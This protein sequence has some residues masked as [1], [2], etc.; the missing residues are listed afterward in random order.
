M[1]LFSEGR[2]IGISEDSKMSTDFNQVP[3]FSHPPESWHTIDWSVVNRQVRG[4]QVRIA[5]A[6][7]EKRWRK[8]K[9]LQRLLTHSFAARTLAVRRVTENRGKKTPGVDGELWSTPQAKWLALGRL[10]RKGYRPAPL[11]RVYIPK[12]DGSRRPLGIPTMRDRAMQALYL[13]ALEPVSETV[14]DRNSYGFRPWRSTADAIEQCFV[15]LRRKH[16]AEWVLEGDIKGCFDNISHDWLLANVPMDKHVLKM[17]LKAGFMESRQLYPTEAGTPQGGIISPVLANL[18]LDGL[19]KVL[20]SHFGKKNTKASYK[21]KVNYVRYADDFIITGI[22]KELLENDVLPVVTAFMAERGLTLS[23]SKTLVTHITEGFDFLGQNLR[24]YNGKLLIK[25]SRKNLQRHLRKIKDIVKVNRTSR[26]DI[27]IKQ[28]NPVLLGWANYHRHV[29][30]KET[31]GYVDYRVWKL[32]WRWSCRRHGNRQKRW[33]KKKYFHSVKSENWVFQST[34]LPGKPVRLLS[35]KDIPIVRHTK[36]RAEAN[37]YDPRDEQYFEDRLE[38]SWKASTKGRKKLQT[39]W[40][41]QGKRCPMCR[42]VITWET[43]WNVHHVMER[44]KGGG[45]ELSN[46]VLLHPNCHRQFHSQLAEKL[47]ATV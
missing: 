32:L 15:N 24:K 38:R 28:L 27:L 6:T 5:K 34:L 8:V 16:S 14:A 43:G 25:P 46:L 18:A 42:S 21:T 3:A 9:A 23:T 35:S 20:E 26:Q 11:R 12:T 45:D 41:R 31:F 2:P 40:T 13:L 47:A 17:W 4:L 29:V 44:Y 19:E 22:S 30:A 36:I 37:P 33:V 39:L 7:R 1:Y 10:K